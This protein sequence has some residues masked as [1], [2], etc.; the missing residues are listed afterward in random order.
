MTALPLEALLFLQDI[1]SATDQQRHRRAHLAERGDLTDI[2]RQAA[3]GRGAI[4][5]VAQAR[6][7]MA[8]RQSS[9]EADL[10]ATEQRVEAVNRRLYGGTVTASRELQAMAA[11]VEVLKTRASGLED[12]ILEL[13]EQRQPLDH[14]L[15]QLATQQAGLAARRETVQ[16]S[17]AESEATVDDELADLARRRAEAA[18]AVPPEVLATY[19]RLRASSDGVA[20]ARLVGNHCDGC[21]LSLAAMELDRI[22]HLPAGEVAVCEQCGRILVRA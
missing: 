20:V 2:D 21:H 14:E 9:A 6:D 10:A 1:D 5:R 8:G 22:R 4:E 16:V 13:M 15:A 18:A 11:D 7:E 17:L 3:A 12:Q 19:E